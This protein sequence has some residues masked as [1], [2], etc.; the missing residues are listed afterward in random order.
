MAVA[1]APVIPLTPVE[2][3]DRSLA[4]ENVVGTLRIENMEPDETTMQILKRYREGEIELAEANRLLD[5]Y[6]RT[7]L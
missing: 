5:E 4:V 7:V 2:L 1:T 3:D 6:S